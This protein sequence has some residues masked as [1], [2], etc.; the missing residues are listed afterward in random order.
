MIFIS[1]PRSL[2]ETK[3]GC[4]RIFNRYTEAGRKTKISTVALRDF[5]FTDGQNTEN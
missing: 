1:V 4:T 5:K 3:K 2:I